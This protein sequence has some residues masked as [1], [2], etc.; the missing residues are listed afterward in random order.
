MLLVFPVFYLLCCSLFLSRIGYFYES[1]SDATY[2]YL[3]NGI[4]IAS[5]HFHTGNIIHPGTSVEIFAGVAI[6]IKHLF[7]YNTVLYQDVLMHPESYLFMCSILLSLLLAY[8]VYFSG[9]YV[10]RHTGS[11]GQSMLFQIA[12]LFYPEFICKTI[13]LDAESSLGICGILFAAYLYVNT[14]VPG[15]EPRN[16]NII[17]LGLFTALLFTTKIYCLVSGIFVLFL[18]KNN[19]Q[20]LL[21][22]FYSGLFSLLL[23]FPLY[24]QFKSWFGFIKAEIFHSG[25]YGQGDGHTLDPAVYWNNITT[26]FKG[27]YMLSVIFIIAFLLFVKN[28]VYNLKQ[29]KSIYNYINPVTGIVVF[30]ILFIQ[31]ISKQYIVNCFNPITHTTVT[32]MKYYYFMPVIACFPLFIMVLYKN[33]ISGIKQEFMLNYKHKLILF[34]SVIF[35]AVNIPYVAGACYDISNKNVAFQKTRSFIEKQNGT[36]LIFI[37]DG[38]EQVYGQPALFLGCY[39]SGQWDMQSYLDYLKQQYP[40]TYIY[41]IGWKDAITFWNDDVDMP[42]IIN[43]YGKA[44]VYISGADSL[45]EQMTLKRICVV[46]K[47]S[48]PVTCQKI[49]SSD[50]KYEDIYLVQYDKTN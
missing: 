49:Y 22:I 6:F 21:Y 47:K 25:P 32:I 46:G 48:R 36:P 26:I 31:V 41:C 24:N 28:C 1:N 40:E 30:F 16:R 15:K 8:A 17:M 23:V 14:Q 13:S 33:G 12:P 45:S 34:I 5:G 44:M 3:F 50:N 39:F 19:R 4:N 37:S 27:N 29:K 11:L 9:S 2:V 10:Y 20:R 18:L 38:G 35:I 7:A 43:K 42:Y